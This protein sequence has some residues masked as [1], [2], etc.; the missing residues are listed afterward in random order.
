MGNVV[1]LSNYWY[2]SWPSWPTHISKLCSHKD[3]NFVMRFIRHCTESDS[4]KSRC[5]WTLK[6]NYRSPSGFE[7][8][9]ITN[10]QTDAITNFFSAAAE[11]SQFI[12]RKILWFHNN[13]MNCSIPWITLK[14]HV[15]IQQPRLHSLHKPMI[16]LP[17][18]MPPKS[19]REHVLL[20]LLRVKMIRQLCSIPMQAPR[21]TP[22]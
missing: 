16:L 15:W 11:K 4:H 18:P 2:M 5:G 21:P 3:D 6:K 22:L 17:R 1:L 12:Q 9:R 19:A 13:Q 20:L 10:V 14:R 8:I 7:T